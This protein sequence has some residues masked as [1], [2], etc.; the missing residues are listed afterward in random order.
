MSGDANAAIDDAG[1][2]LVAACRASTAAARE[3]AGWI[4]TNKEAIGAQARGLGR[5]VRAS[6]LA[7]SR[8]AQAATT[9]LSVAIYGESQVGKSWLC[10]ALLKAEDGALRILVGDTDHDFIEKINPAKNKGESTGLVTRFTTRS[11]TRIE[12]FPVLV[13]LFSPTDLVKI[14]ANS[15]LSDLKKPTAATPE[16]L[17]KLLDEL[18]RRTGAGAGD[19]LNDTL[20]EDVWD[21]VWENF[22]HQSP[23]KQLEESKAWERFAAIAPRLAIEDRVRGYAM[24]WGELSEFSQLYLRGYQLLAQ[25]GF[26]EEAYCATDALIPR[27]KTILDV[28]QLLAMMSG[29]GDQV[30][31]RIA[32]SAR[33]VRVNKS[34]LS[35]MVSELVLQVEAPKWPF[36]KHT[37]LLDFPGMRARTHSAEPEIDVRDPVK[38]AKDFFLR[39]KVA[40]LFHRYLANNELP[41]L[42]VMVKPGNQEVRTLPDAI[43][44]WIH[45]THGRNAT[46]R[47]ATSATTLFMVLCWFDTHFKADR[48]HEIATD[49]RWTDAHKKTWLEL[50]DRGS[51]PWP[52]QWRPGQPFDN[53]YWFR[54]PD[55]EMIHIVNRNEAKQE[56]GYV[57]SPETMA[58]WKENN[59]NN[60]LVKRHMRDRERAWDAAWSLNDGGASYLAQSLAPVC[61]AD[62]KPAQIRS[63]LLKLRAELYAA[64]APF[65]RADGNDDAERARRK[66]NEERAFDALAPVVEA[67]RFAAFLGSLQM[68][69]HDALRIQRRSSRAAAPAQAAGGAMMTRIREKMGRLQPNGEATPAAADGEA[70]KGAA[71]RKILEEWSG[72]LLRLP[73]R[74]DWLAYLALDPSAAETYVTEILA[75]AERCDL[76]ADVRAVIR[77][78]P[79]DQEEMISYAGARAACAAINNFVMRLG[80]DELEPGKRPTLKGESAPIFTPRPP[81]PDVASL[82]VPSP[83]E[84]LDMIAEWSLAFSKLID[85]NV[86]QPLRTKFPAEENTRLGKILDV[87]RP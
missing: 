19:G 1:R 39:G 64:L 11:V 79:Y 18:E 62:V 37:D 20:I 31:T 10:N 26:A 47:M 54:N 38:L 28:D 4:E 75:G 43:V 58:Q 63:N 55:A 16:A 40:Y 77:R 56:T 81:P 61:R 52:Q 22:N 65:H 17:A 74:Q 72:Q 84:R 12:G 76:E 13:R 68:D 8:L 9:P 78:V 69:V 35:A 57:H 21:Y 59:V 85:L 49:Q 29:G 86:T 42:V 2:E 82:V 46:E 45:R 23:V 24:L 3:A 67:E 27:E 5:R 36:L 14:L 30:E 80:V 66:A 53:C 50:F 41:A 51:D 71:A 70:A 48:G 44:P 87:F 32:S 25:L 33:S 60:E 6:E 73:T 7:L 34:M 83:D 15:Y